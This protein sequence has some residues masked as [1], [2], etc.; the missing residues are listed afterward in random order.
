MLTPMN[1]SHRDINRCYF[2][3]FFSTESYRQ[4]F[5][6]GM[7]YCNSIKWFREAENQETGVVDDFEGAETIFLPDETH[8]G[9]CE[10]VDF[11][12]GRA[13]VFVRSYDKKPKNYK[14]NQLFISYQREKYNLFCLSA[15]WL[16]ENGL[17]KE[18]D[19]QNMNNFGE[20]GVF[21]K[22]KEFCDI[23][24]QSIS[25]NPKVKELEGHPVIYFPFNDRECIQKWN[26]WYKPDS[27]KSQQE[28]RIVFHNSDDEVL[29]YKLI[30]NIS[31][32]VAVIPN[33]KEF[34]ENIHVDQHIFFVN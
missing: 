14:E 23:V 18:F 26:I 32:I 8:Y 31:D 10:V 27:Y 2:Y 16:D 30:H 33:K 25:I 28:Y 13:G 6:D 9:Q 3:K 29:R 11:G 12:D 19:K 1:F 22:A 21:I 17:V 4:Q 34:F 24:R 7:L 20:Y 5:I 15:I